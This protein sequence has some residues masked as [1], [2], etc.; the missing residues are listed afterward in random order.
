[1]RYG[2]I[3]K[4]EMAIREEQCCKFPCQ[5]DMILV[6]EKSSVFTMGLILVELFGGKRT[7][8]T[9]LTRLRIVNETFL[10]ENHNAE[11]R[12][13]M[14]WE[15]PAAH[16]RISA[17]PPQ[18]PEMSS[19]GSTRCPTSNQPGNCTCHSCIS[20]ADGDP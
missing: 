2:V 11:F 8:L 5:S 4:S 10:G 3:R 18:N 12:M 16:L 19:T 7:G 14:E 9:A 1:E 6:T 20:T 15:T 17:A 13:V